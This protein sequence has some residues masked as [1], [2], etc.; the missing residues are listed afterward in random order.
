MERLTRQIRAG[1]LPESLLAAV[2][3]DAV[4]IVRFGF[5]CRCF[6]WAWDVWKVCRRIVSC[7]REPN[8]GG[9]EQLILFSSR[10]GRTRI[11]RLKLFKAAWESLTTSKVRLFDNIGGLDDWSL[12]CWGE[13]GAFEGEATC[14]ALTRDVPAYARFHQIAA[15]EGVLWKLPITRRWPYVASSLFWQGTWRYP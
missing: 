5:N 9:Y 4:H 8:T 13:L 15:Q 1:N 6:R 14:F 7:S 12:M 3:R 2:P 11:S 10:S